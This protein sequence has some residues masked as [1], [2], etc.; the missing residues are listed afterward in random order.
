M[1]GEPLLRR[2][3]QSTYVLYRR[4]LLDCVCSDNSLKLGVFFFALLSLNH[5]V[6]VGKPLLRRSIQCTYVLYP[7]R[8]L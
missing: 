3:I 7:R 8:L 5:G 4:R 2:S 6:M 1:V